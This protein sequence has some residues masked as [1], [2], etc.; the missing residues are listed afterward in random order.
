MNS[1]KKIKRTIRIIET[2]QGGIVD[3]IIRMLDTNIEIQFLRDSTGMISDLEKYLQCITGGRYGE[4]ISMNP[5][6]WNVDVPSNITL[7]R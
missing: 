4:D 7:I 1:G 2:I 6:I 3:K 5:I